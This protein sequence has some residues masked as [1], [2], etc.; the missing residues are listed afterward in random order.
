MAVTSSYLNHTP[1]A[2][3]VLKSQSL[4]RPARGAENLRSACLS[5]CM[6]VCLSVREHISGAAGPIFTNFFVQIPC[7]NGSI[8]FWPRCNTLCTSG[9]MDDVTFGR[10]GPYSDALGYRGGVDVYECL[11]GNCTYCS[12]RCHLHTG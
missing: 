7:G 4:L 11:V 9:C 5:V 1:T 10:S 6:F 2:S 12:S 3:L 8:C